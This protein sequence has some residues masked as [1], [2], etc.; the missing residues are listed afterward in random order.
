MHNTHSQGVIAANWMQV[1][2]EELLPGIFLRKLWAGDSGQ[3]ASVVEFKPEAVFP[4]HTH[5]TGPEQLYVISGTL[6]DGERDYPEG[7]FIHNPL[8][9]S[10]I[11]NSKSGCVV[12]VISEE[13]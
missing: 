9:S 2:P 3:H 7:S 6:N 11:P 1:Q 8:G 12:L 10:H 4:L 5:I 13:S